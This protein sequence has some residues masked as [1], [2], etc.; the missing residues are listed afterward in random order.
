MKRIVGILFLSLG[1][2]LSAVAQETVNGTVTDRK[3][4]PMPGVRVSSTDKK[5]TAVALT[6]LDGTFWLQSDR[7]PRKIV[8]EYVGFHARESRT[9]RNPLILKLKKESKLSYQGELSF[10]FAQGNLNA[11]G[12]YA[13]DYDSYY[14][15]VKDAF[16][17]F[18]LETVQGIRFN[19][20]FFAGLGGQFQLPASVASDFAYLGF[21]DFKAYWPV[22]RKFMPYVS[23]DLGC[24]WQDY[25]YFDLPEHRSAHDEVEFD[26]FFYGAY[27]VGFNLGV[28]NIAVGAMQ[29]TYNAKYYDWGVSYD[30]PAEQAKKTLWSYYVK[31]GLKW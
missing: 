3:G 13:N 10:G 4:V 16:P 18:F 6:E 26:R 23:V 27:G 19:K 28:L 20:Y 22:T 8:A 31:L 24:G 5:V 11:L 2:T 25:M 15:D 1:L 9:K 29:Q 12:I 21:V 17:R 30:I 14:Y 7:R